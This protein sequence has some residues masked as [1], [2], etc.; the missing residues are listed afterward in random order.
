MVGTPA[1]WC[2]PARDKDHH[3]K[4][5]VKYLSARGERDFVF[6]LFSFTQLQDQRA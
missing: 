3:H 6:L 1:V 5:E 4:K 2:N